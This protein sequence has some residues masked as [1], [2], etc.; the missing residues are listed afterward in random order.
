M[1]TALPFRRPRLGMASPNITTLPIEVMQYVMYESG[2][3]HPMDVLAFALTSKEMYR[4]VLGVLGEENVFDRDQHRALAG[5]HFCAR[6]GW[7]NA[8]LLAVRRGYGDMEEASVKKV[9]SPLFVYV[10]RVYHTPFTMACKAGKVNVVKALLERGVEPSFL[11]LGFASRAGATEVVAALLE[12]GRVDPGSGEG[13][14]IRVAAGHTE[15]V[16]L[17]LAE[18]ASTQPPPMTA[19]SVWL[20]GEATPRSS[21]SCLQT[22]VL[23]QPPTMTTP[24]V[25]LPGGA[26]PR[27][28]G[29][30]SQT[31]VSTQPLTMT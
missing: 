30:C 22:I 31:I 3:L 2:V 28:F 23:I 13:I 17:L 11:G 18:I 8:A 27:L 6:K 1:G 9:E 26:T 25:W 14:I 29:S 5:I 12:D 21:G 4:K 7:W 24:S 20:P 16:R 19:P 10:K 15:V